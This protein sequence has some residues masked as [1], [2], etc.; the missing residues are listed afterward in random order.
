MLP[1]VGHLLPFAQ[2]KVGHLLP[3]VGQML[4]KKR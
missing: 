4:H 3:K 2:K 1:K